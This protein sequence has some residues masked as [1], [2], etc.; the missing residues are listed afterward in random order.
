MSALTYMA[1]SLTGNFPAQPL[2]HFGDFSSAKDRQTAIRPVSR[3][4][5]WRPHFEALADRIPNVHDRLLPCL[6]L[7]DAPRDRRA[8]RNED[9]VLIP[10]D[11]NHEPHSTT[12]CLEHRQV[13][14]DLPLGPALWGGTLHDFPAEPELIHVAVPAVGALN[15]VHAHPLATLGGSKKP[16]SS[17]WPRSA[18]RSSQMASQFSWQ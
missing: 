6:A 5:T 15:Q 17:R 10:L 9:T 8:L 2:E 1:P 13:A 3:P 4:R 18:S 16:A 7:A 14:V 12:S 11:C